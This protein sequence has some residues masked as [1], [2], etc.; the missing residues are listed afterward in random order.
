MDELYFPLATEFD[1]RLPLYVTSVGRWDHQ[2][3]VERASGFPNYHWLQTVAGEGVL[4]FDNERFTIQ[5]GEGFFLY[6][7][8]PHRYEAK[9]KPW[10]VQWVTFEGTHAESLVRLAGMTKSG[11]YTL[12]DPELILAH[13]NG[14]LTLFRTEETS[15]LGL[16]GSKRLYALL[17][18]MAKSVSSDTPPG[19]KYVDRLQPVIRYIE[20][21]YADYISLQDLAAILGV[22]P[23]YL[24]FLFKQ[25]FQLRPMEYVNRERIRR[26]KELMLRCREKKLHEIALSVGIEHASYFSTLFRRIEGMSPEQFLLMHGLR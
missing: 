16:E 18:D 3:P 20:E 9:R 24:C 19:R 21:R 22:T 25:A 7:H 4:E 1:A 12:T 11:P 10:E 26:S 17:L 6:P 14:I 23:Q 15:F 2:S 5:A 13:M 8:V